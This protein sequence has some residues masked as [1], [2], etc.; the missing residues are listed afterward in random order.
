MIAPQPLAA[1]RAKAKAVGLW[2]PQFTPENG[3]LARRSVEI[4]KDYADQRE[5]FGVR[6]TPDD[7]AR[8]PVEG[9]LVAASS[10]EI[11][12]RRETPENGT[13]HI[14]FPRVVFETLPAAGSVDSAAFGDYQATDERFDMMVLDLF[15]KQNGKIVEQGPAIDNLGLRRQIGMVPF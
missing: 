15:R 4:A 7:N 13:L 10:Q 1:V 9:E 8:V 5:G 14:H 2:C 3:G 11:I 12:F 6:L